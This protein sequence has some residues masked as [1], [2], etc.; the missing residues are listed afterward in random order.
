MAIWRIV[1]WTL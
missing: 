1:V